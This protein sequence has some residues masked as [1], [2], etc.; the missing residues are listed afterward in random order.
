MPIKPYRIMVVEDMSIVASDISICLKKMGYEVTALVS[1]GEEAV[2]KAQEDIPDLILMGISLSGE[3]DGI[4]AAWQIRSKC[5][6][7]VIYLTS[8]SDDALLERAKRTE[9]YAYILKPFEERELRSTVE[10]AL[11]RQSMEKKLHKEI[12]LN[13]ILLDNIPC[14]ALLISIST[15]TIVACNKIAMEAGAVVGGKC[16]ESWRKRKRPC[17]WCLLPETISTKEKHYS[18]V[19]DDGKTYEVYWIPVTGDVFLHC[20]YDVTERKHAEE[21][22][23]KQARELKRSNADLQQFAYI[24]SHDL[25]EPLRM[26]SGFMK[27]LTERCADKLDVEANE[28]IDFA[29]DGAKRM[30]TLI[31]DL[32]DYSRISTTSKDFTFVRC[33]KILENVTLNLQLLIKESSSEIISGVLPTVYGDPSQLFQLFQNL[34]ANGIKFQSE[35]SPRIEVKASLEDGLWVFSVSDNG[36]GIEPRFTKNIFIVFNRLHSRNKYKGTGIGLA[37]C[38]KVVERH[39]GRIWVESEPGKGS[40]FYFTIPAQENNAQVTT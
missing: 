24:A 30:Q 34:I 40:V 9:P 4:E 33:D 17:P 25:Q 31:N 16:F 36:I 2:I 22:I 39:G 14:I 7:S 12:S 6:I 32:L 26:V 5:N 37:I 38:K 20:A 23:A 29:V 11:Y 1:S 21:T 3:M 13:R 27:L 15:Y 19:D 8:Y 10:T 35:N 28:Y 18:D